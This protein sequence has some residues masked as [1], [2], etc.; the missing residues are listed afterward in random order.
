MIS[1]NYISNTNQTIAF[2][3]YRCF[4]TTNIQIEINAF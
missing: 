4:N 2:A 3:V 1:W